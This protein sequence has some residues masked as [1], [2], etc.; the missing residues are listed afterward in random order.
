M[1]S[2]FSLCLLQAL[3]R[4]PIQLAE[5]IFNL[6]LEEKR[7]LMQAQR[8]QVVRAVRCW[9]GKPLEWRGHGTDSGHLSRNKI[10]K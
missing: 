1:E 8:A 10:P 9:Y 2:V 3:P 7:I 4:G 6:L 5:M